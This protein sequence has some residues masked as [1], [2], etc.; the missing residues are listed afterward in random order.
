C[1]RGRRARSASPRRVPRR[2]P[3]RVC[4]SSL[5][6][7]LPR[8]GAGTAGRGRRLPGGGLLGGLLRRCRLLGGRLLRRRLLGGLL[9]GRGLLRPRGSP[10]LPL[11]FLVALVL[12]RGLV[13]A[14]VVPVLGVLGVVEVVPGLVPLVAG[15]L[16]L[17]PVRG[18]AAREL[19]A[20]LRRPAVQPV[21]EGVELPLDHRAGGGLADPAQIAA[22][23]VADLLELRVVPQLLGHQLP[24]HLRAE[25][26]FLP[27][28]ESADGER[29]LQLLRPAEKVAG[30]YREAES[31]S[32]HCGAV[33]SPVPAPVRVAVSSRS[34]SSSSCRSN[35]SSVISPASNCSS[36]R[37]SSAR[38]VAGS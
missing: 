19:V 15:V 37:A 11:R 35:S 10:F 23:L 1:G 38:I 3:S 32:I 9:G 5:T 31:R 26:E 8:A 34:R 20:H 22:Q 18:A 33:P 12:V 14:G 13:V 16:V 30:P 24:D 28:H 29:H 6:A 36:S 4:R 27:G 21:G 17:V 25:V 7:S 2:W